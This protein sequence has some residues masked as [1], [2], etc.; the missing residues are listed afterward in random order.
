M[1]NYR[2]K[3][4]ALMKGKTN[5]AEKRIIKKLGGTHRRIHRQQSDLISHLSV[6]ESKERMINL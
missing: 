1:R 4:I 5:E 3:I 6:F 2:K